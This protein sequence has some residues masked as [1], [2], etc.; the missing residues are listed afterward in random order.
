MT[1]EVF[2]V[3]LISGSHLF[4]VCVLREEYD[5]EFSGRRLQDVFPFVLRLVRQGIQIRM[6]CPGSHLWG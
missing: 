5:L 2:L 6:P 4:S 1:S 3:S